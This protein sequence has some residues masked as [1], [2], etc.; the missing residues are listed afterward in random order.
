MCGHETFV[1]QDVPSNDFCQ[2]FDI[3]VVP[4]DEQFALGCVV[5]NHTLYLK[6]KVRAASYVLHPQRL[7][8]R[9]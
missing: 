2:A 5:R 7:S 6:Q 9:G 4:S 3:R 8:L 1:I